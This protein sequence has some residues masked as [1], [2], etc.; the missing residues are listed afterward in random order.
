[1]NII[2]TISL[3][4]KHPG[5]KGGKFSAL[6]RFIRW[7]IASR[8][9]MGA[10]AVPFIDN[11]LLLVANGMTGATGNIYNGLLEWEEMSFVLHF[12]RADE[13]FVDVGANVGAYTVM[14]AG[15]VGS[16][17]VC[18]E[19]IK[20]TFLHLRRNIA[21]N[22]LEDHV[23]LHNVGAGAENGS[24]GFIEDADTRNRVAVQGESFVAVQVNTLDDILGSRT[25]V[26]IK[27]DV[28]GFEPSVLA[29]AGR[30]LRS[31]SVQAVIV[32]VNGQEQRYGFA[33]NT[34]RDT[35]VANGFTRIRYEPR[36]REIQRDVSSADGNAIFV[37]SIALAQRKV[38]SSPQYQTLIGRL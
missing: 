19:P 18:I 28:E 25:P 2:R 12:L 3:I 27:I 7:Q 37:R 34:V 36:T 4:I 23:D 31:E 24:I 26:L 10:I 5:N 35:L 22:F 8:L 29:G 32:E 20:S 13:L 11:T 21:I 15:A 9:A 17:C 14:A 6:S 38:A 1:M 30:T 33:A 16:R